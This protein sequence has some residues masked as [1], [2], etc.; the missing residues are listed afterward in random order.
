MSWRLLILTLIIAAAGA[1]VG[2]IELG[3]W[4]ITRAPET[5]ASV[6]GSKSNQDLVLDANGKPFRAQPPQPRI[7]GTLGVP[8]EMAAVEWTI[9]AVIATQLPQ[10]ANAMLVGDES[11]KT[12]QE[13]P[14]AGTGLASSNGEMSTIDVSGARQSPATG[15]AT[16][17]P[18]ANLASQGAVKPVP[19]QAVAQPTEQTWQQLLKKDIDQCGRLGFFQRPTCVQNAR[20]KYCT[21]N[22]GWGKTPDC[23]PR[24]YDQPGA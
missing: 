21:P 18:A 16:T 4:L 5:I 1:A 12:T 7:D 11:D 22:N 14:A 23:P 17:P 10:D 9:T 6:S 2:G 20:N 15:N 19:G 24:T 13:L 8:R 3:E